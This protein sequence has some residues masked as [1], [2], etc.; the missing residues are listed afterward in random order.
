MPLVL[1]KSRILIGAPESKV[2]ES[3][4][5]ELDYLGDLDLLHKWCDKSPDYHSLW[6][7]TYCFLLWC[8]M[9]LKF[10]WDE[11]LRTLLEK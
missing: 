4:S 2:D 11:K 7:R 9:L 3:T 10:K 8:Q 5:I 6:N 1:P